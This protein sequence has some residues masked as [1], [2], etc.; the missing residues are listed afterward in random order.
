MVNN[1]Y[2]K[3]LKLKTDCITS[4]SEDVEQVFSYSF[5]LFHY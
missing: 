4:R 5:H 3:A 1:D 2:I